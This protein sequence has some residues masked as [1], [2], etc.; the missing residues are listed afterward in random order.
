MT[1]GDWFLRYAI[2]LKTLQDL[3]FYTGVI[4]TERVRIWQES[5]EAFTWK[6]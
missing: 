2:P 3:D 6:C 4:M 1:E 5:I